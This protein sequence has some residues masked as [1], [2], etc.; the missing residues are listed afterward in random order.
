MRGAAYGVV[1]KAAGWAG[2]GCLQVAL[3]KKKETHYYVFACVYVHT[4]QH[5]PTISWGS[6]VDELEVKTAFKSIT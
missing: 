2:L 5:T 6:T 4:C 1:A 3:K